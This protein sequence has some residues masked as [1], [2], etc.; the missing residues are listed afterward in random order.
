MSRVKKLKGRQ[1]YKSVDESATSLE[2]SKQQGGGLR[3]LLSSARSL[4]RRRGGG[5]GRRGEDD[6]VNPTM[7]RYH[8][9]YL[10]YTY[11]L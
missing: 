7:L 5:E 8:P 3:G 6:Q 10:L 2:G 11:S 9:I 1:N 4:G